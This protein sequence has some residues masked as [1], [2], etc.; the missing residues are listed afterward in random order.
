LSPSQVLEE[1]RQELEFRSRKKATVLLEHILK[2]L[3]ELQNISFGWPTTEAKNGQSQI[4]IDVFKYEEG[5]LKK[6]G[7]KVGMNGLSENQRRKILDGVF[8]HT[9][10]QINNTAYLMEWG[11]PNTAKRLQK[12]AESLAAFTRNAKRRN[13]GAFRKAIYD[14]EADLAY[15]KRAYYDNRRFY[16]QWPKTSV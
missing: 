3:A 5:L 10:P 15:L 1:I 16:F 2:R 12:L 6:C 4:P 8:I 14:W 9:L 11:E 7:Y 13:R